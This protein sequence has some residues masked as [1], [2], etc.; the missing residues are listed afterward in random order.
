[1]GEATEA[2]AGPDDEVE[3]AVE[4]AAKVSAAEKP[5][6]DVPGRPKAKTQATAPQEAPATAG[7]RV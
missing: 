6:V 4:A 3:S 7:R 1:M 2:M 5:S